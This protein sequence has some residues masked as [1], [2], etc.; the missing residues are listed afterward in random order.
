MSFEFPRIFPFHVHSFSILT[1]TCL[2]LKSFAFY[3]I[4]YTKTYVIITVNIYKTRTVI[5]TRRFI[6]SSIFDQI[7]LPILF[8]FSRDIS[9]YSFLSSFSFDL[10]ELC[11]KMGNKEIQKN[12][13]LFYLSFFFFI[14]K[15]TRSRC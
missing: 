1:C 12:I 7:P 4:H 14:G 6:L 8:E 10:Q 9:F 11:E 13:L 3:V 2:Y 5:A 15:K